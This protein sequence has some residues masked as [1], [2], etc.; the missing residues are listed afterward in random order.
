MKHHA[1]FHDF[2]A[3]K[4][5]APIVWGGL[6]P[7]STKNDVSFLMSQENVISSKNGGKSGPGETNE[8]I[9]CLVSLK[10]PFFVLLISKKSP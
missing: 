4:F 5:S 7:G 6:V 3:K 2:H 8:Y 9:S 1:G 10:A